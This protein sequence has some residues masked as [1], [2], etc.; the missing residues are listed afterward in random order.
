MKKISLTTPG[1]AKCPTEEPGV[2]N[3]SI[4]IEMMNTKNDDYTS[5]QYSGLNNLIDY[6]E[7]QYKI[8][9]VLGHKDISPDRKTDPW[10]FDWKEVNS[11]NTIH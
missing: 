8:K 9:Y 4:G 7:D 2:N 6:L 10:N 3:F 5:K 11:D 1:L